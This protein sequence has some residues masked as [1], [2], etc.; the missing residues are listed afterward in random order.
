MQAA[1]YAKGRQNNTVWP[2]KICSRR[3]MARAHAIL[4]SANIWI[5]WGWLDNTNGEESVNRF[6]WFNNAEE[7]WRQASGQSL[8]K[9]SKPTASRVHRQQAKV[10]RLFNISHTATEK[11][12]FSTINYV[13]G[14]AVMIMIKLHTGTQNKIKFSQKSQDRKGRSKDTH[15]GSK[16]GFKYR[17]QAIVKY[18]QDCMQLRQIEAELSTWFKP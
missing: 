7:R 5:V 17:D 13:G 8:S 15:I 12:C 3:R 4:L 16:I 14:I 11:L 10:R 9:M 2:P 1:I 6:E 18:N